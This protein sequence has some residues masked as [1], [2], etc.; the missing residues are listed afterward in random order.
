MSETKKTVVCAVGHTTAP[1]PSAQ[2]ATSPTLLQSG[3]AVPVSAPGGCD[4]F[5]RE[6]HAQG[7]VHRDLKPANVMLTTTGVKLLDG[8]SCFRVLRDTAQARL[9]IDQRGDIR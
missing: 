2:D 1:S 9:L 5:E 6:A 7:I 8:R 3:L 4:R